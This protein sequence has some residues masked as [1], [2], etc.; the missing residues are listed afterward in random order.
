MALGDIPGFLA[1][2]FDRGTWGYEKFM[3]ERGP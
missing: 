3:V 1:N 2:S